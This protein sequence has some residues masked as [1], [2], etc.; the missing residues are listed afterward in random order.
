MM[1][2]TKRLVSPDPHRVRFRALP[3]VLICLA[4]ALAVLSGSPTRAQDLLSPAPSTNMG[5]PPQ[6]QNIGFKPP[7]DGQLPLDDQFRDENGQTVRLGAY[8]HG[9]PVILALVYYQCPLLCNQTLQGLV[10]SLKMLT[11][12]A[13]EDFQVVVIS[14]D[15]RE[16]PRMALTKKQDVLAHF[17][18]NDQDHGWHFLTGDLAGIRRLTDAAGFRFV[19]D[20][21]SQ[22]WAHASGIL[23]LTPE[24]RISRYFYGIEYSPRDVRWGLIEA[25]HN[26][27][28]NPV[29]QVL[30]FCYHYDPASG[31]YGA[32]VMRMLRVGGIL[33]LLGLGLLIYICVRRARQTE[34]LRASGA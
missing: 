1:A 25:S 26:R 31:K 8:F 20:A 24:G 11:F 27:I 16:T 17:Q 5:L 9:K 7:L 30:L 21:E 23:V 34:Q 33:T 18:R 3:G 4:A 14:F 29:D 22:M 15:S 19:W 13:G 6:Y 12:N 32:L 2:L 28:G 10:G